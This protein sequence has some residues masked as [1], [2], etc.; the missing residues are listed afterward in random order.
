[1]RKPHSSSLHTESWSSDNHAAPPSPAGGPGG[2]GGGLTLPSQVLQ[3]PSLWPHPEAG[4]LSSCLLTSW[5][6]G[7]GS[8]AA[9]PTRA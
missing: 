7:G 4:P 2:H 9:A 6:G 1:M 5:G 3:L 8:P